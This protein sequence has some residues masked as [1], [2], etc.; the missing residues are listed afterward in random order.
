MGYDIDT[1][2]ATTSI[3]S[4]NPWAAMRLASEQHV[5]YH[6]E[7]DQTATMRYSSFDDTSEA[8]KM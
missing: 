3:V 8:K 6:V 5:D 1:A 2:F 4:A 7:F